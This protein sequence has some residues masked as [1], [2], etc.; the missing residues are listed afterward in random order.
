E[1]EPGSAAAR[2]NLATSL[3]ASG[4]P[5]KAIEQYEQA[6]RLRPQYSAAHNKWGRAPVQGARPPHALAPFREAAP[7]PSTSA[8]PHYNIGILAAA[9]RDA[10]G[11]IV[12][13]REAVRLDPDDVEALSS[14]AW[15]LA[16]SA[17]EALRSPVEAVRL[18]NRAVEL[19]RRRHA[20]PLDV[21]AAAQ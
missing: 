12:E 1:L 11:A 8:S 4:Q 5:A 6:V 14:L 3:L 13:F 7:L 15:W 2:Y 18:A 16:T 19:D 20:R 17:S 9:N 21:L 10:S